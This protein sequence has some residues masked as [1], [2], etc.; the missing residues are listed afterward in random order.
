MRIENAA[1]PTDRAL[2]Q[3]T[4]ASIMDRSDACLP[5]P[6][7]RAQRRTPPYY[8]VLGSTTTCFAIVVK[9]APCYAGTNSR[10]RQHDNFVLWQKDKRTKTLFF[11]NHFI[12][13]LNV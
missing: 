13:E 10:A 3:R 4:I 9:S 11:N 5:S 2:T 7:A 12:I 8:Y 6:A 1:L